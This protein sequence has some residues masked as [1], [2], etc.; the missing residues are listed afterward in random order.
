MKTEH[1]LHVRWKRFVEV[2]ER[3]A[4]EGDC[5]PFRNTLSEESFSQSKTNVVGACF[6]KFCVSISIPSASRQESVLVNRI[7]V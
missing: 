5:D 7:V 1:E 6:R 2:Q 3:K 4:Y